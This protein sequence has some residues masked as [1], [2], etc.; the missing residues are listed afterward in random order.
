MTQSKDRTEGSEQLEMRGDMEGGEAKSVERERP[1]TRPALADGPSTA[2]AQREADPLDRAADLA[3]HGDLA[4]ATS[5]YRAHL[6]RH[7]EDAIARRGLA[8]VLEQKG[9]FVGALGELGR[10]IDAQPEDISLL[11]ARSA[12][13]MALQRYD[14][15][16]ADLRR[17]S[18]LDADNAEVLYNYGM[19]FCKKARWREAIVPL[20]RA[21]ELDPSNSQGHYYLAEAY[22]QTDQL[23]LA[24]ASY[25][26]SVKLQPTNHRALKG[27]GI[28]LDKLG[29][30]AEATAAYQRAREALR[31]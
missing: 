27:V 29:R 11:C 25:E 3:R 15:A 13:Q 26:E 30:P 4:E 9:D 24:L 12:V 7:P 10:A 19:L 23:K 6:T 20:Q 31:R 21:V 1:P 17:A 2:R 5:A 16:E 14:Q 18:K 28:V 22:N 8:D